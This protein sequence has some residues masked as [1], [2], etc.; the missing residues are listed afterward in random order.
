MNNYSFYFSAMVRSYLFYY[1]TY[2]DYVRG[3]NISYYEWELLI[4][5][6]IPKLNVFHT[7]GHQHFPVCPRSVLKFP[8]GPVVCTVGLS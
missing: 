3:T 8:C 5:L 2:R 4:V 6:N 1:V 7:R